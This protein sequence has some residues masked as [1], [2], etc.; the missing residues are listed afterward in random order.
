[1]SFEYEQD[2]PSLGHLH[3]A[4]QAREPATLLRLP[5]ARVGTSLCQEYEQDGE[6]MWQRKINR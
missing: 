2:C 6:S 1:M 4:T 3:V 5:P